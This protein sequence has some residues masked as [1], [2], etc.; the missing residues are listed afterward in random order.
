LHIYC[1]RPLLKGLVKVNKLMYK[2]I[3]FYWEKA[4]LFCTL[5]VLHADMLFLQRSAILYPAEHFPENGRNVPF[6]NL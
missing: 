3:Y 1:P 2:L 4:V 6:N 5:F